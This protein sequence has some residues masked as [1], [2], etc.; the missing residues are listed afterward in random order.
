[1][2]NHG[3]QPW[4][5]TVVK[6]MVQPW[7]NHAF[8]HPGLGWNEVL[9]WSLRNYGNCVSFEQ[10]WPLHMYVVCLTQKYGVNCWSR[11]NVRTTKSHHI[12]LRSVTHSSRYL[13][14]PSILAFLLHTY[15]SLGSTRG[16]NTCKSLNLCIISKVCSH[17]TWTWIPTLQC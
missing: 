5:L 12:F 9:T 16:V 1:M 14:K 7:L 15:V 17:W 2:V 13:R 10:W 8:F 6:S 11:T 3:W 4:S